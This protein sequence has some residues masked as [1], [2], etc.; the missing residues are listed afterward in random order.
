MRDAAKRV[1]RGIKRCSK[2]SRE[3]P[4]HEFRADPRTRDGHRPECGDCSRAGARD[5][6][7]RATK[8]TGSDPC[9]ERLDLNREGGL[10]IQH[11]VD[12][13]RVLDELLDVVAVDEDDR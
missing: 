5:S 2:C 12:G 11:A 8:V 4:L 3:V 10:S 9:F 13:E 6:Y 1:A 7:R